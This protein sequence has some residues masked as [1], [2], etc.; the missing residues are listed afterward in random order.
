VPHSLTKR[1]ILRGYQA[2]S[3]TISSGRSLRKGSMRCFYRTHA[4]NGTLPRVGFAVSRNVRTAAARN[5]V[6]RWM[7]ESYRIRKEFLIE[8]T[9][10][11]AA[12][13]DVV[14]LFSVPSNQVLDRQI[15]TSIDQAISSLLKELH[16]RFSE[17]P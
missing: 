7:R 16:Q 4:E 12:R 1:E 5:R 3:H 14:F 13:F 8:P 6:R 9:A 15:R 17:T 2:F 11:Q 10:K